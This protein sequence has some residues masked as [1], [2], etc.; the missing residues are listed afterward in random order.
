MTTPSKQSWLTPVVLHVHKDPA[1]A[2]I[3]TIEDC[4]GVTD[5][6][7]WYEISRIS[8]QLRETLSRIQ[9]LEFT[10]KKRTKE[11]DEVIEQ[12][13]HRIS[14]LQRQINTPNPPEGA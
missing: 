10:I 2:A 5:E 12:L 4:D 7:V 14:A 6:F 8:T 13:L 1:M 9:N 3:H 11:K